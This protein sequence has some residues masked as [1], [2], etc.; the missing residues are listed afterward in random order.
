MP[1]GRSPFYD[2]KKSQNRLKSWKAKITTVNSHFNKK[3]FIH[4]KIVMEKLVNI[5]IF[6]WWEKLASIWSDRASY[7]PLIILHDYSFVSKSVFGVAIG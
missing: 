4:K 2:L 3:L 1:S 5:A 6:Y 7:I